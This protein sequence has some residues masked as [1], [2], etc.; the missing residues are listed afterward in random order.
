MIMIAPKL[1]PFFSSGSPNLAVGPF[2]REVIWQICKRR[3]RART[4][5][6]EPRK[7]ARVLRRGKRNK[8]VTWL[9]LSRLSRLFSRPGFF[10]VKK[11]TERV[12]A[13][14]RSARSRQPSRRLGAREGARAHH[15]R[16]AP[17]GDGAAA[18]DGAAAR[19]H[20]DDVRVENR[21]RRIDA[22][23]RAARGRTEAIGNPRGVTQPTAR[24]QGRVRRPRRG[25]YARASRTRRATRSRPRARPRRPRAPAATP[26][27][28][29]IRERA[30][31]RR[32]RENFLVA[33]PVFPTTIV[34]APRPRNP[35][36]LGTE[37]VATDTERVRKNAFLFPP[38]APK[39]ACESYPS[40]TN[41]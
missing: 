20:G 7:R 2:T 39:V 33:V 25:R 5:V 40:R 17:R 16:L 6:R 22:G 28:F 31:R 36:V 35:W 37:Q 34:G 21:E 4:R 29:D 9:P 38:H 41:D 8:K 26:R 32:T 14:L 15:E 1:G 19:V 30:K 27:A 24:A 23:H 3:Y 10:L 13:S 12:G 11:R 18:V